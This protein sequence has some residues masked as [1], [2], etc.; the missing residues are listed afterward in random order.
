MGIR[1][2][3]PKTKQPLADKSAQGRLI[4]W[5]ESGKIESQTSRRPPDGL[6]AAAQLKSAADGHP[7]ITPGNQAAISR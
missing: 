6:D 2:S 5:S 3:P 7:P 1:P 4:S